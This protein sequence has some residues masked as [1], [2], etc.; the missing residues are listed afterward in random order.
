MG[1]GAHIGGGCKTKPN[2]FDC[3][4]HAAGV[5]G[6]RHQGNIFFQIIRFNTFILKKKKGIVKSEGKLFSKI[7]T[8]KSTNIPYHA[9]NIFF[10]LTLPK[11]P[12]KSWKC[13]V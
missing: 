10:S 8:L 5:R 13:S 6:R 11:D 7:I 2:F 4:L 12:A 3:Q 9:H 1:W